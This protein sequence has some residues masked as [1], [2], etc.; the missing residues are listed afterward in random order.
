M[1]RVGELY[2]RGFPAAAR[3]DQES[4]AA[5]RAPLLAASLSAAAILGL[6]AAILSSLAILP[7]GNPYRI[8]LFGACY[9]AI[10]LLVFARRLR[11]GLRA[12]ILL[13]V[14][15][16]LALDAL[17]S[18][19]L[20]GS[21][22][23]LLVAFC[24]LGVLLFGIRG[25]IVTLVLS[26]VATTAVAFGMTSGLIPFSVRIMPSTETASWLSSVGVFLLVTFLVAIPVSLLE[27]GL[28]NAF[29]RAGDLAAQAEAERAGLERVVAERAHSAERRTLQL[30]TTAEIVRLAVQSSDPAPLMIQAVELIRERFGFYHAS[31]FTL[32][33]T[34]SS[35][36]LSASTGEAGRSLLSR[37]HRLAVGS[38]SM[39][40]WVTGNRLPRV[41]N[42]VEHDPFHYKN[43]LLPETR[44]ELTLPMMV[45]GRLIGVLDVQSTERDAFGEEDVRA[46]EAIAGELAIAV[47]NA[48]LVRETDDELRRTEGLVR[49]RARD[50]WAR[51]ARSGIPTML[52]VGTTDGELRESSLALAGQAVASGASARS[53]DGVE[54]AVPI[55]VRAEAIATITAR[56]PADGEP[57]T[58][59]DVHLIEAAAAQVGLALETARQ[60]A[61]E[62]RRVAELEVVNRVS[63]AVSQLL[64]L[65]SLYRVVHAQVSEILPQT[66]LAIGVYDP[67]TDQ[68]AYPFW[69]EGSEVANLGLAPLG[70]DLAA[71]VLR[72]RQPLTLTEDLTGQAGVLGIDLPVRPPLSWMGAPLMA[73]ESLLGLITVQD[74][75]QEGRFTEDD[76]ALLATLASQVATAIQ[77]DRLLEETQ[78][79]ARRERLIH[80]ITSKMRRAPDIRTILD[81][82]AREIG[83]AL[84]ASRASVRLGGSTGGEGEP[85]GVAD[86]SVP[87]SPEDPGS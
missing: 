72:T 54:V 58:D 48:R 9:G 39:V 55:L 28:L 34:G 36:V 35:A 40:G 84:N 81:T 71:Y 76:T 23:F 79:T 13:A 1:N 86:A 14:I 7:E 38:A 2:R 59:D 42:D 50:S 67:A 15:F 83:R 26:L 78:R 41:S 8:F 43:P 16:I 82:T 57:W 53:A 25:A 60:Y 37:G 19:G 85:T 66:D 64:R 22:R 73:G 70:N 68:L 46:L 69:A 61:E 24:A 21:G 30:Q 75:R 63:Q 17:I 49:G 3:G 5:W 45:G 65:D 51:F 52:R 74:P 44:A 12:G 62:Q 32:E 77:N 87:S 4:P 18:T 56:R 33:E 10:L 6:P 31:I 20:P 47:D 80:E 27:G 11:S 29:R